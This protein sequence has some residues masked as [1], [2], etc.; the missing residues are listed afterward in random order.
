MLAAL[1]SV[2]SVA[3]RNRLAGLVALL[4]RARCARRRERCWSCGGLR[5]D[6]GR[7]RPGAG[8][9]EECGAVA[10]H[11]GDCLVDRGAF[12]VTGLVEVAVDAGDERPDPGDLLL[13]GGGVGAGPLVD[14]VDGGG[15]AFT[16]AEQIVE[17]VGEVGQVG[18]VGAEVV[19]AGAAEPDW[20]GAAAGLHVGRLG[21][22]SVG[23]GDR[24]D[25]VTGVFGVQQTCG[26]APDPFAVP[27]ETHRGHRVHGGAAP[28]FADPV[29]GPGHVQIPVIK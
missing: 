3:A 5:T 23:D 27:V 18:H 4:W 26:L 13:A 1:I 10:A 8:H 17:I 25:G 15:E 12:G 14:A 9:A 19:A 7:G 11:H 20:A 2:P 29:V 21:A 16:G 6:V 24:A 28:V 22:A